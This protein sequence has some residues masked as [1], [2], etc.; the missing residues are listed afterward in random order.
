VIEAGLKSGSLT[1]ARFAL[2]QGREVFAVPG[3]PVDPRCQGS[4]LLIKQGAKLVEN[5]DDILEEIQLEAREYNKDGLLRPEGLAMTEEENN[6]SH[7]A[8]EILKKLSHV[9]ILIDEITTELQL[10]PS[11]A[12]IALLQLELADKIE[13]N[14][15][16]VNLKT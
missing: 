10:P 9:P 7:V 6:L 3:S 1:T 4:N 11:L 14:A 16:R 2:E 5:I 15:G 12:N 13:I 8:K